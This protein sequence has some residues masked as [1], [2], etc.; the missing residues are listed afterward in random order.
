MSAPTMKTYVSDMLALEN[1]QLQPLK[2]QAE[3][4]DVNAF[5][6]AK[7]CVDEALRTVEAHIES[8]NARLEALGGHAGEGVKSGVTSAVGAVAGVIDKM[9]KTEV[10]KS[11][12][13]DYAALCL[14]SAG[15]TMLN[16][17]AL[18][19]SD[20]ETASLAKRHLTDFASI[21]MKISHTL[22]SVVLG[23]LENEGAA[24]ATSAVSEAE[25]NVEEAWK[26]GAARA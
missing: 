18:G 10:S 9:R 8:L 24:I 22:P 20:P 17:A 14:S 23:E 2:T 4:A 3:D 16:T 1:H 7:A 6:R 26:V 13:D 15:Y 25:G 5:P 19:M 21:V 11:L 12:R